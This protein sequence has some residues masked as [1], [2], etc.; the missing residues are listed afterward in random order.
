MTKGYGISNGAS[1]KHQAL[2]FSQVFVFVPTKF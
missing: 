1:S 2:E